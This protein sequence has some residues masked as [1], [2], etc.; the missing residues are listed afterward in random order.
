[1]KGT[2]VQ[3]QYRIIPAIFAA[4]VIAIGFIVRKRRCSNLQR[5]I[6]FT[7]DFQNTFIELVEYLFAHGNLNTAAYG[8]FI[9]D[10]DAM[11]IEL[12]ADGIVEMYDPLKGI[13]IRH[14]QL[15]VNLIPELRTFSPMMRTN[16]IIVERLNQIVG[17]TDDALRRHCGNLKREY[18]GIRKDFYNP[19][20]CFG[21]GI[22]TILR[23]PGKIL[24]WLGI[25]GGNSEQRFCS[26][27]VFK[28]IGWIATLIGFVSAVMTIV[29]GWDQCISM[30]ENLVK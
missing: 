20:I 17:I 19:I 21:E 4:V 18:E 16:S 28:I 30:L 26:G 7:I 24:V 12:G 8:K 9:N 2:L 11:Q 10:A 6:A 27:M 3:L 1:M 22:R 25:I 13:Q 29:L 23:C 5:Q 15:I 14:Y